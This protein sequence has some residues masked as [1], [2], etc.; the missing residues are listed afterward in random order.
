MI[1]GP[2]LF[3]IY[4]ND[5]FYFINK[6]NLAN[7]ADDNTPYAIGDDIETV[8]QYL[9]NDVDTLIHWF[10]IKYF[11]MN[12]DKC[13]LLVTN[14]GDNVSIEVD[15]HN[16][17]GSK[18]VKLLGITIDNRLN[19]NDHITTIYKKASLKLHALARVSKFMG[20]DKLRVSMK[21]FFESQFG[22]C[23]LIWMYHSHRLNK[24][25]K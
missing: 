9:R 11:R 24:K 25:D 13:K 17:K 7:Y 20:K 19:F 12:P 8:L 4:L 22:Y 3:D 1:L 18:S 5:I 2:F 16:I 10:E 6:E 15:G 23:S 21:S 14:K